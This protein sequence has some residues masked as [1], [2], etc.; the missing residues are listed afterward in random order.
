MK[1]YFV[2]SLS[3]SSTLLKPGTYTLELV[4]IRPGEGRSYEGKPPKDTLTFSFR[5]LT[6]HEP[7]NRT[8]SASKDPRG[9]ALEFIKQ[10]A[11]QQQP[12]PSDL[13]SGESLSRFIEGMIGRKFTAFISPSLNGK[14]NDIQSIV[15]LEEAR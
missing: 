14:Y 8:V 12:T 9:K 1:N 15:P 13:D 11:G 2:S 5:E 3:S 4:S 6:S 10:L 7:I